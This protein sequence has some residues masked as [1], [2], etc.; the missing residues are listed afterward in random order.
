MEPDDFRLTE[1][2][3]RRWIQDHLD[4][5]SQLAIVAETA[6]EIV[7]S[8]S[9]ENSVPRRL[10]HRG[11]LGVSVRQTR[12]GQGI[13]TALLQTLIDWAQASPLIEKI[14]LSVFATN[15]DAIR[16]YQRLGFVEEGR[17]PHEIKLAEGQYVDNVLMYRLV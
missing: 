16:L 9:F 13:G 1:A 17:Q 5:P 7:G 2:Q 12:R 11:S 14:G 15:V 8:L 4:G 10:T 6:D 3:E